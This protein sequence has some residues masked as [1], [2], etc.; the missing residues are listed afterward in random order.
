MSEKQKK[1][2]VPRVCTAARAI[3]LIKPKLRNQYEQ[4]Q[5]FADA[6]EVRGTA[7]VLKKYP[8]LVT[9]AHVV[10]DIATAP[11]EIGG[12]LVVGREGTYTR[13][14][15]RSLD[16]THDLAILTPVGPDAMRN[17]FPEGLEIAD[18]YPTVG[19]NALY[20]GFPLGEQLMNQKHDPTFAHGSV[21]QLRPDQPRKEI[22]ITGPVA[23]GFSGSPVAA[24]S[25]P[26]KVIGILS[27]SPVHEGQNFFRAVS[28]EHIKALAEAAIS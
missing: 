22:Q 11:I 7:F 24:E 14:R 26:D 12:L 6:L 23:G 19:E 8:V 16:F 18:E 1:R 10:Q 13:A 2:S 3:G 21:A 15:V 27:D 25:A 4:G 17:E 20:A 9:C 28:F 5:A